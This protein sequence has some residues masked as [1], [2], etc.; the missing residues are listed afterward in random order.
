MKIGTRL[1]GKYCGC[2]VEVLSESKSGSF[3]SKLIWVG[4]K[5]PSL[6]KGKVDEQYSDT[7]N[8]L[9]NQNKLDNL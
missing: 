5:C 6:K 3:N 1:Q 8:E 4:K 7:F 2:I 9:K